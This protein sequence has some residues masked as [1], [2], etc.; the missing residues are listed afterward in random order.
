MIR[1]ET[2]L[3]QSKTV[4]FSDDEYFNRDITGVKNLEDIK[5]WFSIRGNLRLISYFSNCRTYRLINSSYEFT[6]TF[7][8]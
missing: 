7:V 1:I 8:E 5:D 3:N 2:L 6:L 4:L